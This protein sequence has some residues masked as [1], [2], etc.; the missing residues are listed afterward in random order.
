LIRIR[1]AICIGVCVRIRIRVCVRVGGSVG[2]LI[3]V[4]GFRLVAAAKKR[5]PAKQK[6]PQS[7]TAS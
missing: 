3:A 1:V 4:I 7:H 5:R 6:S 2:N